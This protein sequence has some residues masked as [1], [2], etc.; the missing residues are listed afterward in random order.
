MALREPTFV[1]NWLTCSIFPVSDR[2]VD[3]RPDAIQIGSILAASLEFVAS[4]IRNQRMTSSI[5]YRALLSLHYMKC[6]ISDETI[7]HTI[8]DL[9]NRFCCCCNIL[10]RRDAIRHR[11]EQLFCIYFLL[12][13]V[14]GHVVRT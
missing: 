9:A 10:S 14:V 6:A 3:V 12:F 13:V 7:M 2:T 11:T 1:P 5:F 4:K 8:A